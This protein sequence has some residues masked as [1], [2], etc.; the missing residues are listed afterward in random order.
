M[1]CNPLVVRPRHA[2]VLPWS[3][4]LTGSRQP[5]SLSSKSASLKSIFSHLQYFA[6]LVDSTVNNFVHNQ[7][8]NNEMMESPPATDTKKVM[9]SSPFRDQKLAGT[10]R[11]EL[12]SLSDKIGVSL[13]PLFTSQKIGNIIKYREHKPEIINKQ[14]VVYLF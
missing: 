4:D 14:C 2:M 5:G 1:F 8:T 3:T 11:K 12:R 13:Q 10:I 7:T 6:K 9:F